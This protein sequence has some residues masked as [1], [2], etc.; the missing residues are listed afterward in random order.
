[1]RTAILRSA[2]SPSDGSTACARPGCLRNERDPKLAAILAADMVG[3]SRLAGVDEEGTLARLK[4][5]RR[6]PVDAGGR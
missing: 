4:T 6:E 3:Y 2:S 1:M 5:L